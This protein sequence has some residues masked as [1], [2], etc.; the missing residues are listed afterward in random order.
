MCHNAFETAAAKDTSV[1]GVRTSVDGTTDGLYRGGPTAPSL[2]AGSG[3][4]PLSQRGP[5][6]AKNRG[7]ADHTASTSPIEEPSTNVSS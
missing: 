5:S 1:S 6:D 3:A 2:P 7:V 4:S